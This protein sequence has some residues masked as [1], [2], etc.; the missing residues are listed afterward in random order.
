MVALAAA[1][2]IR[3]GMANAKATSADES[4]I[5]QGIAAGIGFIGAGT[6]LK[7]NEEGRIRGLT[8]AAGIWLTAAVGV[9]VG[10]GRDMSALLVTGL[11]LLI[12]EVVG[13]IEA[14]YGR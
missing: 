3:I 13:K 14:R 6:I 12:L 7:Q 1:L 8:T 2:F 9:A 10:L 11:A 4:R 5:I